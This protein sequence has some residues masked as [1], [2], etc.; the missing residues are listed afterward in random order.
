[1]ESTPET[2]EETS[3][4]I[5]EITPMEAVGFLDHVAQKFE[6]TRSDHDILRSSIQLLTNIVSDH[7]VLLDHAEKMAKIESEENSDN[8]VDES[9]GDNL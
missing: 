4:T 7:R 5:V 1:M 9:P 8:S 3:E 6:G 2:I